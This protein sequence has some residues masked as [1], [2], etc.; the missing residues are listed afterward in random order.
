MLGRPNQRETAAHPDGPTADLPA[1]PE[2]DRPDPDHDWT[3]S[4]FISYRTGRSRWKAWRLPPGLRAAWR[5]RRGLRAVARRHPNQPDLNV[6]LDRASLRTGPLEREILTA[7]RRSRSLIVLLHR[8]TASSPWVEKEIKYWLDSV[9]SIDRLHLVRADRKLDLSWDDG[10]RDGKPDFAHPD[11]VPAPLRGRF[12]AEQ[13]SWVE[14]TG[15]GLR[16]REAE[17]ARLFAGLTGADP[18]E[19]LGEEAAF[20]RRRRNRLVAVIVVMAML[21]VAATGAA[22]LAIRSRDQAERNRIAALAQADAAEAILASADS[23]T[24]AIQRAVQASRRS[25]NSTVRSA[26]L[27]VSQEARRLR[28][29]LIY[30]E[31]VA[32]HP[33]SAAAFD[34]DGKALLAW[35][36]ARSSSFLQ[37]W[38]VPDGSV[39]FS[40]AVDVPGLRQVVRAGPDTV[41]ACSDHGPVKI[42][43]AGGTATT[44][45]LAP[46][47]TA[48]G[49]RN[50]RVTGFGG[51]VVALAPLPRAAPGKSTAYYVDRRAKVSTIDGIDSMASHPS[52]R[53]ALLAGPSGLVVASPEGLES[54]SSGGVE[55]ATFADGRGQFLVRIKPTAW[56]VVAPRAGGWSLR[57]VAVP[58]GAVDVAPELDIGKMTGELAWIRADGTVG[59][60]RDARTTRVTNAEGEP[61]W[62]PYRTTLVPLAFEDFVAVLGNTATVVRP[63]TGS[64]VAD[65]P[66]D[67]WPGPGNLEWSQKTVK[68][69]LGVPQRAGASPV[70][71]QCPARDSVLIATDLPEGGSLLVDGAATAEQFG[72]PGQFSDDCDAVDAGASL[73][74]V[75]NLNP[76]RIP[77]RA[78]LVADSV[79]VSPTGSQLA[80]VRAGVP[81]EVLSTVPADDLPRPWE[82]T[83]TYRQGA[84]TAFGEHTLFGQ[85]TQLIITDRNGGV[86]RIE[87]GQEGGLVAARP[88]GEG[89]VW[90]PWDPA[91]PRRFV[92][93]QPPTDV[94]PACASD[95]IR[96][97]P[98]PGFQ[99]PREAAEAQIPVVERPDGSRVDCRTGAAAKLEASTAILSYDVGRERGRIVSRSDGRVVITS[100]RR[101]GERVESMPG[102]PAG[103]A[104]LSL[105]DSGRVALTYAAGRPELVVHRREGGA[106][107]RTLTVVSGIGDPAAAGLVDDGTLIA[108]VAPT[109]GLELYDAASGRRLIH[110]PHLT[111]GGLEKVTGF[112][113]ARVGDDLFLYLQYLQT[114]SETASSETGSAVIQI[115]VGIGALTRQLCDL[116]AAS[117]C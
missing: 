1:V 84:V 46:R 16:S 2:H 24:L 106:W 116:Y 25:V 45:L 26:M 81:I 82:I 47:W 90:Q 31:D 28:R 39:Q 44:S 83:S 63:P 73:S 96:Y 88:D 32:G 74:A 80:V 51:G 114:T 110:D 72:S 105:D 58:A 3:Y 41:V 66:P 40:G 86:R 102:P 36:P 60:S 92:G 10:K 4:A 85:G 52:W 14:F 61:V 68:Q 98:E 5:L 103:D 21:A 89:G 79:A 65:A 23:P 34:H 75:P 56:A 107:R 109:G 76:E 22:V 43:L 13:T 9:G 70:V 97:I 38:A 18:A 54:V 15:W 27:A 48:E 17:V 115:P 55:E 62:T 94:A 64:Y 12:G 6:F 8:D 50:C 37:I 113:A 71:A 111:I 100:W 117:G 19:F 29:A 35:G 101:G 59:W 42:S 99:G 78:N 57:R 20:Q 69:R 95:T 67:E 11:Q 91:S 53:Q 49:K 108:A 77:I 87:T 104:E 30:P 33:P 7:L 112:S 93:L